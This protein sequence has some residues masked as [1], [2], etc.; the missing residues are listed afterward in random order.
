MLILST[1]NA[2]SLKTPLQSLLQKF[3][4]ESITI[5]YCNKNLMGDLVK[6]NSNLDK[7][8]EKSYAILLRLF[9]FIEANS[10]IDETKQTEHLD[11]ILEQITK[12]KYEKKS[13][14][15][16]FL[17]PSP[18]EFNLKLKSVE[19]LFIKKLNEKK[20]H[21]L[22][23]D[24]VQKKHGV[25]KFENPTGIDTHTPYSPK[26]CIFISCFL[27]RKLHAII[28]KPYKAIAVD[29]DNTLW[30][31]AA[32]DDGTENIVFEAHNIFLQN[33]LKEQHEKG[34]LIF[35][36]S[37]NLKE[38]TIL[39][40]FKNRH[41][42][43]PLKLDHIAA[44]RINDIEKSINIE[45]LAKVYNIFP[46]SFRFIDDN[47]LEINEVSQIPGL[48]CITMPQNIEECENHWAFDIDEHLIVTETDRNR[49]EY[50]K[51]SE[52]KKALA[53]RFNDP[54]EYLRSPQL[55]QSITISKINSIDSKVIERVSQLSG[56]TNQFNL[57]PEPVAKEISEIN[58][59][60]NSDEREIFIGSIKDSFS[61]EDITAIAITSLDINS[62]TVNSFFVSCRVF[63]RGME[64]E[65]LKHI[66]QFSQERGLKHINLKFKKSA[67]N[68]PVCSFLNV[69]S[70]ETNKDPIS[71]VLLNISR[72]YA[73]IHDGLKFLFKRLNICVDF[74]SLPLDEEFFLTLST[75]KIIELDIDFL[76]RASFKVS[77]GCAKKHQNKLNPADNKEMNEKYLIEL[78]QITASLLLNE[79]SLHNKEI[80]SLSTTEDKVLQVCDHYLGK[81]EQNK[82]LVQRGLDSLKATELRY[83][84]YE[85]AGVNI[86]IQKMLCEKTTALSLARYIEEQKVFSEIVAQSENFYNLNMPSSFQQQRIW[87]AEQQE[88][89][90]NSANYHMTACYKV[91]KNLNIQRF[92]R[93]CYELIK[94]YDVFGTTFFMEG[95]ELKQLIL[96]PEK[97]QLNFQL[98]KLKS[99]SSLDEAIQIEMNKPWTMKSNAPHIHFIIFEDEENYHI[100]I[101]VHHA[102]FD[103]VSL[104]N[105]LDT[106]FK[107]YQNTLTSNTFKLI[108]SPPQYIEFIYDQQKKLEDET[109]HIAAFN[110]WKNTLSK[111]E[112][113]TTLPTDQSLST[114]KPVTEQLAQRYT[115]SLSHENLLALKALAKSTGV[116]CFSA[117][118]AM[119]GLL[120]A[121]YTYQNNITLITATNGRGGHPSFDKMVGF[122]VNLLVLQFDLDKDQTFVGYLNLVNKK[123]IAS[124]EFQHISFN[125]I[126]EILCMQ[127][128]KDILS[129]PAFI[130]QSYAIPELRID[131]EI[132]ELEIPRQPI[133]FDLRRTCRF[134]H[135]TLFAQENDQELTFVIEYAKDL[136]STSLIEGFAKNFLYTI[137]NVCAN[138]SRSLHEILVVCDEER[139]KLISLGQG[140]QLYY[141]EEDNLV[142]R[143]K[144]SVEKYPNNIALSNA[145]IYLSYK[146]L[147]QQSASLAHA[148]IQKRAKQGD[149]VGIFL[150]PDHLFF[151]AELAILKIGAVF[152]P[153]SKEDPTVRIKAIIEDA[154]IKFFITDNNTKNLFDTDFQGCQISIHYAEC[155][156]LNK[157]LPL[158]LKTTED[159]ACI[160]Y[161][162]GSTGKPKG[163]I[164]Q[165]K[166]I[167]R[168]VESPKFVKVLPEDKIAQ[169]AN[170]AFDAAQLECWLAWNNGACLV[171]FGKETILNPN[172]LQNALTA[173]KVTHM[174]LTAGLFN[175][176]AEINPK[177]FNSLKY[178]MVGGDVVYKDTV[179][180]ILKFKNSPTIINGYG[181]TETSIFALTYT[182]DKQTLKDFDA[183]PIGRPINNTTVKILTA[184]GM[185]APIGAIGELYIAGDGVGSYLNLPELEGRFINNP[186]Q[187]AF[188]TGDLVRYD[189][190]SQEIMFERRANKQ[191]VKINGNL[192]SLEEVRKNLSKHPAIKQAE[193]IIKKMDGFNT[194]IAFFILHEKFAVP[195][196]Q[197]FRDF[198]N[199][200]LPLY[201][202]PAVYCPL[203][204]FKMNANGKLDI[205]W[206]EEYPLNTNDNDNSKK[207]EG[208]K[209][210]LL[211][212]F[213]QVLSN[214]P[215]DVETDFFVWG[216]NSIQ[217]MLLINYINDT[218]K[219]SLKP[220]DL[221]EN[222]TITLLTNL[223]KKPNKNFKKSKL[224]LLKIGNDHLPAIVFIHPAGG[225]ISCFNK[226]LEKTTF[227]NSCY[228]IE[229]PF[230]D[231]KGLKL[232]QM[233]QM[234][235][236]Y[237]YAITKELQR[238][239]VIVGFSFGGLLALEI[240]KLFETQSENNY[241]FE[242]ILLDT[243]VVSYADQI[244]KEKLIEDVLAHCAKQRDKANVG[245]S[246]KMMV[247][248]EKLCEHH[249]EIGFKSTPEQLNFTYVT[250]FKAINFDDKFSDMNKQDS[251]N[252]VK[253]SSNEKLFKKIE[254][255][256]SHYDLLEN[257]DNNSL[258][259]SFSERIKDI[260]KRIDSKKYGI[261]RGINS[262]IFHHTLT[263]N[264]FEP[265]FVQQRFK[266]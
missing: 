168:V 217:A 149:N 155:D 180:K 205:K 211:K 53:T 123:L 256:A 198:L 12:L 19:R 254:I 213:K 126:Q 36:C 5:Q 43:M 131:N 159:K 7:S 115:F 2:D 69:L 63:R 150:E 215:D 135:F 257:S 81:F 79:F 120:I 50:Y 39:D 122:F 156:S 25:I 182:F 219:I 259:Q 3:T 23:L 192:V 208:D 258:S 45:D 242:V 101:H 51:Q 140:P 240:A 175:S 235:K 229:D 1:F 177:L 61:A 125:K 134:G 188:R 90:D 157:I 237:Y 52:D 68:S 239:I 48:L 224:R 121:S 139:N 32:V 179:A 95:S 141:V 15:I 89:A 96:E 246:A 75:K 65:M 202:L 176:L 56:K 255:P 28:Q 238:P 194:L 26:F 85:S 165:E 196:K 114:F 76:I 80:Y 33:Y 153:L 233:E 24:D 108:D 16:V 109:Y 13:P 100:F 87:F 197:E 113:V 130:Y 162:S 263:E 218:F 227:G 186:E 94:L 190:K 70:H 203:A 37:R 129:S 251:D 216:G 124:Q 91:S 31:G 77:E 128:I 243:W 201:M 40:V 136:F 249:Q 8:L 22:S 41:A 99:E 132:A 73:W 35:L 212:I 236:N 193:I 151:V 107:I 210:K 110:F 59:I 93:A 102:I 4:P 67:R 74:N 252:F 206:L 247:D 58:A 185:Q 163:V 92:Q 62:L 195:T 220:N 221:H 265:T 199:K 27:A 64:F 181:P 97:R 78:K 103:A 143:F 142:S 154:N 49:A 167:F 169:T 105:C 183:S 83:Y 60:V 117:V 9:D 164:L 245:N 248:L 244:T 226:L 147:D 66:A 14:L 174:W 119:F 137:Q 47:P 158:L 171:L 116:T 234:A 191:Q 98:K 172:L 261:S 106:L 82:S 146:E 148:L 10:I 111:I 21:T 166:G 34:I 54:V 44:Y 266:Q 38:Q 214:F 223:I 118:N 207:I 204:D 11:N 187:R 253:K 209:K 133:I 145:K 173:E 228:G 232:L 6:L 161:T 17:C 71:R 184:F 222:P 144:R 170:Q 160:L 55:G 29:C 189:K 57:F 178:L 72:N 260:T 127:G 30:K 241:L 20:I 138:P 84:L 112:T 104:K 86:C 264:N 152:I 225:G 231:N 88:S 200:R 46:D 18:D 230:L 262:T 250:L 42:E